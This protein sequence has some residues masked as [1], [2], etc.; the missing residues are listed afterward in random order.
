MAVTQEVQAVSTP[1]ER[2]HVEP[3]HLV[4]H[5]VQGCEGRAE[6]CPPEGESRQPLVAPH[7][8]GTPLRD[9]PVLGP[10]AHLPC[11]PLFV[12][13]VF[14]LALRLSLYSLG[15]FSANSFFLFCVRLS[16]YRYFVCPPPR[17][18]T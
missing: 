17:A 9:P 1:L 8:E 10:F 14:S 13:S 3:R 7:H 5:V 12:G 11:R 16:W 4:A 2:L 15:L 6:V 18:E